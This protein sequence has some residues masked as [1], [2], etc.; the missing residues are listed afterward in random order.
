[1][2]RTRT[3]IIVIVC[4]LLAVYGAAGMYLATVETGAFVET[5]GFPILQGG[6]S[7]SYA[8]L[9]ENM[10]VHGVFSS[11]E[12]APFQAETFRSPGYPAFLVPFLFVFHSFTS[13][14]LAQ[15]FLV[16]A[17]AL[18]VYA[19][20][21]RLY[22]DRFA[23]ASALVFGLSPAII[24][25]TFTVLSDILF[26]FLFLFAIYLLFF[27][28][29][30]S[31]RFAYLS[32]AAGALLLGY[33]TLV[34]PAGLYS[35]AIILPFIVFTHLRESGARKALAFAALAGIVYVSLLAP[36]YLRNYYAT[37]SATLSS[38]GPYTLLFYNV[39][40]FLGEKGGRDADS[41]KADIHGAEFSEATRDDLQ[42]GR[43]TDEMNAVTLRYVRE[44]PVGYGIYHA[45]G[46]TNFFLASS[47]KDISNESAVFR[48][49]LLSTP[50]LNESEV[51]LRERLRG[52]MVRGAY[53]IFKAE[54]LFTF[55]RLWWLFVALFAF[56]A[57]FL[58]WR[59]R[60]KRLRLFL[61]FCLVGYFALIFGP[62]SYPRYRIA[63][64]P[65][66]ILLATVG[67]WYMLP[68]LQ[69]V[70]SKLR[71]R[72]GGLH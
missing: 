31:P 41:V 34:R 7:A 43:Y 65:F 72:S 26:L 12:A 55:E 60:E 62:V 36:W 68:L 30:S 49:S 13:V 1:M 53:A 54:P 66:L 25:Y 69:G 21:R 58:A 47:L 17:S 8:F 35:I 20:G 48:E 19:M 46:S 71:N 44:D 39:A 40:G 5:R 27:K 22:S 57:P 50:L 9:A 11:S 67:F 16:I 24:F 2:T 70:W 56:I 61:F 6:D 15:V 4:I 37:G 14:V 59:D 64:E 23:L 18:V 33:A 45:R 52:G 63:S 38:I 51:S 42:S 3:S 32:L 28:A 29:A 10:L